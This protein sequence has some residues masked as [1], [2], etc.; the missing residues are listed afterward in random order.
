[1]T[2]IIHIPTNR[3][4]LPAIRSALAESTLL[5]EQSGIEHL[6]L[7]VEHADAP[8]VAEHAEALAGSRHVHLAPQRW[9]AQLAALLAESSLGEAERA[10]A[11]ELLAPSGVAYSAGPNKAFLVAAALGVDT[12][13]RRD[14]D[15]LPDER[16][17]GPAYPGV[18]ESRAIGKVLSQVT[19][20]ANAEAVP[21]AQAEE[22]VLFVGSGMFGDPPHDRRELIEAG[23]RFGVEVLRL[24]SPW[25]SDENLLRDVRGYFGSEPSVRYDEDFYEFDDSGR[26][27]LGVSC[28]RQVFLQLPEMPLHDA[29]GIDYFQKNLLYQLARPVVFHSRKMRHVYDAVR[30]AQ[31]TE[32]FVDYSMRDLRYVVLW[33]IWSRHNQNIRTEP[34]AFLRPDGSLDTVAY[35]ASFRA[36]LKEA[37]PTREGIPARYAAVYREAAS[38]AEK[39]SAERLSAVADE[40]E[41]LGDELVRQV[42]AGIEDFCWLIERWPE[43][44]AAARRAGLSPASAGSGEGQRAG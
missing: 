25:M 29:L 27:E 22:E 40:A 33:P 7:V 4:C 24:S 19:P 2:R 13:H 12:L 23:E 44:I 28:L 3:P 30:V 15:H 37:L 10:K 42:G 35:V 31:T 43:L 39:V 17:D 1:V 8:H 11:V 41:R 6:V 26:T 34:S 38:A 20:L 32:A 18:L 16:A 5:T 14:S 9:N 36:A 21:A